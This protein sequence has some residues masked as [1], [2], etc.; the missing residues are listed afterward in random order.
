[1]NT[2]K[3]LIS[4]IAATFC[5]LTNAQEVIT[6]WPNGAPDAVTDTSY[7]ETVITLPNGK[8]RITRVTS[9]TLSVYMPA[10]DHE[11]HTAIVI[12]PGGGYGRLCMK[13]EGEDIASKLALR[14]IVGI[15]LKYRLPSERIMTNKAIG[16]LQDV[17]R[18]IRIVRR[19]A[20]KWHI[21]SERI[22]VMGFSAGGHLASTAAL[23][24]DLKTYDNE[25]DND[26]SARPD[27]AVL[28]YPVVTMD[29]TYTHRGSRDALIGGMGN[30]WEERMSGEKNVREGNPPM[31]VVHCADDRSVDYHN[32]LQ[33]VEQMIAHG[34]RTEY[35]LLPKGGHGFG[36]G[37]EKGLQCWMDWM[38]TFISR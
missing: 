24:Y 38:M 23:Q 3:M 29:T 26:I 7:T 17:Q 30:E 6:L 15:V 33:L 13:E 21:N 35:H 1:M 28:M 18:A 10:D 4:A 2:T 20:H 12:C 11:L 37:I 32:S 19:D 22:G 36:L 14:G 9:P 16:P 5:L 8:Q 31:F 25:D 34:N 27:F